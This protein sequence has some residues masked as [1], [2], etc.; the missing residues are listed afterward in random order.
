MSN[1]TARDLFWNATYH[2]CLP[3][4]PVT[5]VTLEENYPTSRYR[6]GAQINGIT[7]TLHETNDGV[8]AYQRQTL[9][10]ELMDV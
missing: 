9:L 10:E 3:G 5:E 8:E 7:Y 2:G 4:G 1:W 6:L